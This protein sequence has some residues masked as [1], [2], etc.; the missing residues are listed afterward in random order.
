MNIQRC[1]VLTLLEY[2]VIDV[3]PQFIEAEQGAKRTL[4]SEE[5][6]IHDVV[7]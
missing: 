1:I 5:R 7:D 6:T 4:H 3:E 2:H